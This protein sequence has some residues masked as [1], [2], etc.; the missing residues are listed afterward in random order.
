MLLTIS[1][2]TNVGCQ[3]AMA[4]SASGLDRDSQAALL[5]L[6]DSAPAA[7]DLAKTAKASLMFPNIVKTGFLVGAEY[8]DGA[9]IKH[10][11][12][13][14]YYHIV[15]ASYGLQAGVQSFGWA[16]FL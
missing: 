13:P 6:Y 10:G 12:R 4:E 16:L 9:L 2:I 11:K 3:T 8:G 15:A 1:R 5:K 14:G 7:R